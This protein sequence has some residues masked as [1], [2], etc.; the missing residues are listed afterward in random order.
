MRCILISIL[1]TLRVL[2]A[3]SWDASE[4]CGPPESVLNHLAAMPRVASDWLSRRS[5]SAM[6]EL[7]QAVLATA[8]RPRPPCASTRSMR[9]KVLLL[10]AATAEALGQLV[11]LLTEEGAPYVIQPQRVMQVL[12]WL[13][14]T[15][16]MVEELENWTDS[17]TCP[18]P[19]G[20]LARVHEHLELRDVRTLDEEFLNVMRSSFDAAAHV[21]AGQG[22]RA[23][24]VHA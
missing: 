19:S 10:Q 21:I 4:T 1:E 22:L 23:Q 7:H 16:A 17:D 6:A 8:Y 14:L 18:V 11:D 13:E 12:R 15:Q 5:V 9:A 3:T 20:L 24:G 2:N